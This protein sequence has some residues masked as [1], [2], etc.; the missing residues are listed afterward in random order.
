MNKYK[1]TDSQKEYLI[2]MFEYFYKKEISGIP[3]I[4]ENG[5]LT[6]HPKKEKI[7]WLELVVYHI[8]SK[9]FEGKIY[10]EQAYYHL[11]FHP[12]T[13]RD[14]KNCVDELYFFY[15]KIKNK[16]PFSDEIKNSDFVEEIE[17]RAEKKEKNAK[18][19]K[20]KEKLKV[21]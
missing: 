3:L 20:I 16:L 5:F 6:Y 11:N 9:I 2:Q 10:W 19:K 21:K 7:Y 4:D 12:M 13:K 14:S 18:E 17:S 15:E 1:I 8:P